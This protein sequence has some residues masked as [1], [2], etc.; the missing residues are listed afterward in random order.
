MKP[1][2]VLLTRLGLPE[3]LPY[4]SPHLSLL[5][6]NLVV[7]GYLTWQYLGG[8][9]K[10]HEKSWGKSTTTTTHYA[11]PW[12]KCSKQIYSAYCELRKK[13]PKTTRKYIF[14]AWVAF[15]ARAQIR[16]S[17]WENLD[18][19]FQINSWQG[20]HLWFELCSPHPTLLISIYQ[21]AF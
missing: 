8:T 13:N 20:F 21:C 1:G 9:Q 17:T 6:N 4:I 16:L 14:S 19:S 7:P 10:R 15:V 11:S 3:V 18:R 5:G 12:H 2:Y